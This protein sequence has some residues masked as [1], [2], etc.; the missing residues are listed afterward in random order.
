MSVL[1]LLGECLRVEESFDSGDIECLVEDE[2]VK[3]VM[4]H[5]FVR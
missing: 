4:L 2:E 3:R 5:Q 1:L